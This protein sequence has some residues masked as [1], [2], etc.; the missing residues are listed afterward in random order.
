[1]I[2]WH[3]GAT[4]FLFRWIFRDPK[5][6]VR[7]LVAGAL[8][9]D[10]I[11][12][13]IGTLLLA[14]SVS[15]GEAWMHSLLA[16]TVVTATV[17]LA[18]RRGRRRRAWMALAIGMFFHLLL[19]GMWVKTEVFLWPLFGSLPM[20]PSPYW[21]E[22]WSRAAADPWR[23]AKEAVGATYLVLL[24]FQTGLSDRSRRR[25]LVRTGRLEPAA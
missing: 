23:W 2:A 11:D 9:P 17:L 16:P 22:V 18:T 4:L 13:P 8:L 20:G 21:A 7:F 12:L 25:E 19:D 24:W 10:L 3:V 5:V 6:D 1:M 14:D 15:S